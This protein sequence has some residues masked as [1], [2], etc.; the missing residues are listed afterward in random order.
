MLSWTINI[1]NN[2][3]IWEDWKKIIRYKN[4]ENL[5]NLEIIKEALVHCNVINNDYK[6]DSRFSVYT[7]VLNRSFG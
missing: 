4:S 7:F 2:E 5:P 3:T 1:R 6:Q